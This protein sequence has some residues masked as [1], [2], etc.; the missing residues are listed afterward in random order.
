[1]IV[2]RRTAC[3]AG[4]H[5]VCRRCGLLRSLRRSSSLVA[6][7]MP[8]W[9]VRTAKSKHSSITPHLRHIDLASS[10]WRA[11]APVLLIGKKS[12]GSSDLHSALSSH[13]LSRFILFI[14]TQL[15]L[16]QKA[17]FRYLMVTASVTADWN[18][19]WLG[20]R[21]KWRFRCR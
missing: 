21:R 12:S 13:R 11:P 15:H 10:I 17:S 9:L 6:P 1:V 19:L 5:T 20:D 8:H 3:P 4:T 2:V 7:H 14:I 18:V 16:R